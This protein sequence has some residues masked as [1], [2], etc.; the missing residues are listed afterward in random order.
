MGGESFFLAAPA[1]VA[2]IPPPAAPRLGAGCISIAGEVGARKIWLPA[3]IYCSIWDPL[4][5]KYYSAYQLARLTC[6]GF[7]VL[8]RDSRYMGATATEA[9]GE[10]TN[11]ARTVRSCPVSFSTY[12]DSHKVA[13]FQRAFTPQ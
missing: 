2:E 4:G 5:T 9:C 13:S 6:V 1:A 12:S 8:P 10:M 7:F 3:G 11:C